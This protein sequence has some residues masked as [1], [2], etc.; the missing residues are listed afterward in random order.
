[1]FVL[2]L[3]CINTGQIA[4]LKRNNHRFSV[5][6]ADR[7]HHDHHAHHDED[8]QHLWDEWSEHGVYHVTLGR[9]VKSF[10]QIRHSGRVV[11]ISWHW[12]HG[13]V[14][15]S[16]TFR[17]MEAPEGQWNL[18][19]ISGAII[20]SFKIT[21]NDVTLTVS[22]SLAGISA[23]THLLLEHAFCGRDLHGSAYRRLEG[24]A[25]LLLTLSCLT[26]LLISCL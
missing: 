5:L 10:L 24:S 2:Y 3:A 25:L 13:N 21:C 22:P 7:D 8:V 16:W 1:M 26:L 23:D 9:V 4:Y 18:L 14:G 6:N 19:L 15:S 17:V 11:T 12:F 20:S